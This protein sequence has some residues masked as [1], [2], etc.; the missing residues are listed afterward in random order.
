MTARAL[1]RAVTPAAL[2]ALMLFTTACGG[3]DDPVA[4]DRPTDGST[5]E[6]AP[7]S[8]EPEAVTLGASFSD[9]RVDGGS[10]TEQV[11]LNQAVRIEVTGDAEEEVHVHGYDVFADVAPAAPAVIELTADIPGVF[12]V[13]LEGPGKTL[14]ELEVR[15]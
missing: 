11:T 1:R 8:T 10:R 14:F 12:E 13:E 7:P 6:A 15:G 2:A 5:T 9:G 4:S 3:D